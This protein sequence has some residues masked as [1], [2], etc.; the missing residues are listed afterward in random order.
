MTPK[1]GKGEV[2]YLY[3]NIRVLCWLIHHFCPAGVTLCFID[4]ASKSIP[5]ADSIDQQM[6]YQPDLETNHAINFITNQNAQKEHVVVKI[7]NSSIIFD[8]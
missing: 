1:C 7:Q 4:W 8:G 3:S 2:P 5:F 6:V